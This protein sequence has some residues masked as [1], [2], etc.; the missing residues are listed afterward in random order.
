MQQRADYSKLNGHDE[1]SRKKITEYK[2]YL[3]NELRNN[4]ENYLNV[5][6]MMAKYM[7]E[8]LIH[9]YICINYSNLAVLFTL[10]YLRHIC[11]IENT[12]LF[13]YFAERTQ[14]ARNLFLYVVH[15]YQ[16]DLKLSKFD[17]D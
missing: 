15:S 12:T 3:L 4:G 7:N 2:R 10:P 17:F 9:H 6:N 14:F 16:M 8:L 11:S 1:L 5:N 13:L